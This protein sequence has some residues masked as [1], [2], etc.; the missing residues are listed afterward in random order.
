MCGRVGWG[1]DWRRSF[2]LSLARSFVGL[3]VGSFVGLLVGS[4]VRL[5][6]GSFVRSFGTSFERKCARC[7]RRFLST[8]VCAVPS[9]IGVTVVVV[10]GD[11]SKVVFICPLGRRSTTSLERF[12]T[13]FLTTTPNPLLQVL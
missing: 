4:F 6:A 2:A 7:R 3:L 5:L 9:F 8:I 1:C 12:L 10:M 13:D 11:K